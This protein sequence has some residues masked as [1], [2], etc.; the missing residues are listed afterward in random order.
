M[1][2]ILT[3]SDTHGRDLWEKA[4]FEKDDDG[5]VLQCHIGK[6]FDKV[7]FLGDYVDAYDKTNEE[8]LDNLK[9]IIALKREYPDKVVLFLGNH[10]FSYLYNERC[11]GYRPEMAI[12][13][14]EILNKNI[15]L[16]KIAYQDKNVLWTHAGITKG[17]YN[18]YML[19]IVEGKIETRYTPYFI[20]CDNIADQLNLMFEFNEPILHMCG[21]DRGGADK[22]G[23][24]LWVDKNTLYKK[25]IEGYHQVVGH[26][27]TDK[28]KVYEFKNNT[29]LT[30]TDCENREFYYLNV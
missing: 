9:K 26:T 16:F 22:V 6:R 7:I 24:P 20:L 3:V 19:P 4:I 27:V 1:T 25:P 14:C 17:W 18:Y 29:K 12:D 11:S 8:I 28:I 13:I 15:D 23:G 5:N 10:E 21:W 2:K 30:F